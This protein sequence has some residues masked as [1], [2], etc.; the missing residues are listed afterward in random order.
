MKG[1]VLFDAISTGVT[2]ATATSHRLSERPL[3]DPIA[4][5][6]GSAAPGLCSGISP[7]AGNCCWGSAAVSG[8]GRTR[9]KAEEKR[10]EPGRHRGAG[11]DSRT[12]TGL[13]S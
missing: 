12:G 1:F 11:T 5:A 7:S 8:S 9:D 6:N 10:N 13:F 4:P 2:M 3:E